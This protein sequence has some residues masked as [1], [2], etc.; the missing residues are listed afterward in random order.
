MDQLS[1]RLDQAVTDQKDV[2]LA[3]VESKYDVRFLPIS[4]SGQGVVTNEEFRCYA[5]GTDPE[6][7]Y[8]RVFRT[9][10][11]GEEVF[12]DDYFGVLI[13]PEYQSRVQKICQ[14]TVG[15]SKA[16]VH[17][18]T[19]AWFS[20]GLT[21]EDTIDDA[22]AMGEN[23]SA[24]KY[25][26]FEVEP[27]DEDRFR[28]ACD[29]ICEKLEQSGLTGMVKFLGLARGQLEDIT[30]E[31]HLDQIPDKVKPDGKVC[32]MMENRSV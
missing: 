19:V 20:D 5:E 24:A 10:E 3:Y 18:Y 7:D 4:Y 12:H 23:L 1:A 16:Y 2:F 21:G 25:I 32:L 29:Q 15:Q 13:R 22:I 14:D 26:Y 6:R 11:D 28:Q 30:E 27:G 31:G 9:E 8:V 17:R